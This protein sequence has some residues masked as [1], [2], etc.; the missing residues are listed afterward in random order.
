MAG[1]E[2]GRQLLEG[3][4]D[5]RLAYLFGSAARE[6]V[7]SSSDLDVAVLFEP[8]PDPLDLDR[9]TVELQGAA[10][11]DV[12]L[13]IL[14]SAPPVL[15]HE[16]IAT[17]RLLVSRDETERVSFEARA[18]AR[19]LDTTHLRRVQYAY[20]REAGRTTWMG[21]QPTER[22]RRVLG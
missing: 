8:R 6:E 3:R 19:Y 2:A 16:I 9:F 17:G 21:E 10:R 11:R 20:L 5:V 14:D 4:G 22:L 13:I 1:V 7:R 15:A 18:T 12:D